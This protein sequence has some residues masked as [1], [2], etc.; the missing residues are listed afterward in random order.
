MRLCLDSELLFFGKGGMDSTGV[1]WGVGFAYSRAL[2]FGD[3]LL[4]GRRY[5]RMRSD[6]RGNRLYIVRHVSCVY[7]SSATY[8]NV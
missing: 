8:M 4:Q 3:L 1:L 5:H 2:G 6:K 7:C